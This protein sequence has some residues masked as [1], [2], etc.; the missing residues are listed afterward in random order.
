[1]IDSNISHYK[2]VPIL[3][4]LALLVTSPENEQKGRFDHKG[5][6]APEPFQLESTVSGPYLLE[7]S[8]YMGSSGR[9]TIE[10]RQISSIVMHL[11]YS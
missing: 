10:I 8:P 2:I 1:M 11:A 5:P 7:V 6:F 9:Y 4:L 3:S